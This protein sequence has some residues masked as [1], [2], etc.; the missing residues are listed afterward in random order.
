MRNENFSYHITGL[1]RSVCLMRNGQF[2]YKKRGTKNEK[3]NKTYRIGN[4]IFVLFGRLQY[5]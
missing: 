2:L 3:V 1:V 5:I 4:V